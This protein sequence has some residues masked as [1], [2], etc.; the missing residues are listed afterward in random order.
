MRLKHHVVISVAF[1]GVLQVSFR[2]WPLTLSS[3]LAGIL[4]DV[5]HVL[6][7]FLEC[8]RPFEWRRFFR[9]SYRREYLRY[10]LV[11]HAWEWLPLFWLCAWVSGWNPW[12]AG[13]ALGWAQHMTVDQILNKGRAWAYFFLWRW[14]HKFDHQ[15]AFPKDEL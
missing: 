3:L 4:M 1:S 10:F 15:L 5:D 7:Y 8:G 12:I 13:L 11:V 2:S 9:A 14:K 6:D